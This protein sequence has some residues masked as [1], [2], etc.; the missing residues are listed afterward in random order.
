MDS[1]SI[2]GFSTASE[3]DKNG[4]RQPYALTFKQIYDRSTAQRQPK[5]KHKCPLL[6]KLL[7]QTRTN[8]DRNRSS[9]PFIIIIL[10]DSALQIFIHE[11]QQVVGKAGRAPHDGQSHDINI[12]ILI[13]FLEVLLIYLLVVAIL[14]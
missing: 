7:V 14:S 8:N 5:T 13:H 4:V 3:I 12:V 10:K 2:L 1:K 6:A 11:V 9:Q